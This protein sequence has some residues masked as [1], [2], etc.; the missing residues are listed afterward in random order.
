MHN[1]AFLNK[2]CRLSAICPLAA[3]LLFA[4]SFVGVQQAE[5]RLTGTAAWTFKDYKAT[6]GSETLIDANQFSQQYSLYWQKSGL[7]SNGR[8]GHYNLGLGYEWTSYDTEI[9]DYDADESAGKFLYRGEIIL[10]PGALPFRLHAFSYDNQKTLLSSTKI[11]SSI[12]EP[13]FVTDIRNGQRTT[14]GLTLMVGIRNGSYL[15]RYREILAKYPRLFIDYREDYTRDLSGRRPEHYR[16]RNLAF[17]SLNKKDNWFHYRYNEFIDY[18]NKDRGFEERAYILGTIDHHLRRQWINM[19]NWIKLSVDGS[20]TEIDDTNLAGSTGHSETYRLNLFT[21]FRRKQFQ[22]SNFNAF[23]RGVDEIET[24]KKYEL[25][26]YSNGWI[27]PN[28]SWR[29][30][31]IN[32]REETEFNDFSTLLDSVREDEK[33]DGTY[34]RGELSLGHR[35]KMMLMARLEGETRQTESNEG[36]AFRARLEAESNARRRTRQSYQL[37]YSVLYQDSATQSSLNKSEGD[38][39]EQELYG[40]YTYTLSPKNRLTLTQN[41]LLGSGDSNENVTSYINPKGGIGLIFGSR[42]DPQTSGD[43]FHSTT[44]VGLESTISS[45]LQN[46]VTAY[47]DFKDGDNGRLWQSA[48]LQKLNYNRQVWRYSNASTVMIGDDIAVRSYRGSHRARLSQANTRDPKFVV[49][50]SSSFAYLPNRNFEST[51]RFDFAWTSAEDD[52]IYQAYLLQHSQYTFYSVRGY[53]R[54]LADVYQDLEYEDL[55]SDYADSRYFAL[56]F[57]GNYY[58][59]RIFELG[60][61]IIYEMFDPE[62]ISTFKFR[63]RAAV[64]FS[65]L[66]CEARYSYGL[67][68]S[69]SA[70]AD[71]RE[72]HLFE[73]QVKKQ[74]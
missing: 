59:Y 40:S 23:S 48:L 54:K 19:T 22:V 72:E 61:E 67:G 63:A 65:K 18:E 28:L 15:G 12:L 38:Y 1:V 11:A 14:T 34:G 2:F 49:E 50:H 51:A 43:I 32:Y 26:V 68:T 39:L 41:F 5:A 62:D 37:G 24:I 74:F 6:Q 8:A 47:F 71:N 21:S 55:Q 66:Q 64:N 30:T 56:T 16:H 33:E 45:R 9:N 10:A 42:Y 60:G 25:P 13:D 3:I 53:I 31:F 17:V 70:K 57:G 44:S 27:N 29:S 52:N 69:G 35:Q 73:A 58:P 46:T 36:L 20:L 4:L 7:V